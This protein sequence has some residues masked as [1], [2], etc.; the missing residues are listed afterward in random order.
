MKKTILLAVLLTTL[1]TSR[2]Q[3]N[4]EYSYPGSA[5]LTELKVSGFKYFMMD[6]YNNQCRLFNLDHSPWKTIY[7][8][9]PDGMYLYD[10]R[11]VSEDLFNTDSKVEL[12]YTCYSYDTNL[13]YFTYKT[14]VINEDGVE[15]LTIAGASFTEVTTAGSAG[16]KLLAYAYDYSVSPYTLITQV[17]ALP[18]NTPGGS[19][20]IEGTVLRAWPNPAHSSFTIPCQLPAGTESG[21]LVLSG[22]TGKVIKRYRVDKGFREVIVAIE[23][24]PKGTYYYHLKTEKGISGSG[25]VIHE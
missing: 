13:L 21:E 24:L 11:H 20:E 19:S 10:V 14:W 17:Y 6:V 15:L 5:A 9:V 12:A 23:G 8:P 2:A 3:I 22:G 4:L 1:F 7:L 18:G 25:S 16:V